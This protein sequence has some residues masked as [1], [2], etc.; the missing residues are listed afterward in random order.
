MG[1]LYA[2]SS[3]A[4]PITTQRDFIGLGVSG[5]FLRATKFQSLL[6]ASGSRLL[7][8]VVVEFI[9]KTVL[10]SFKDL[11]DP[12][13]SAKKGACM[14]QADFNCHIPEINSGFKTATI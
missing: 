4:L 8:P 10:S 2:K 9:K 11:K 1:L 12:N 3:A 7:D 14:P 13:T 5:Y 6:L